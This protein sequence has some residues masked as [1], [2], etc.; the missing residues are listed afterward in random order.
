MRG[1]VEWWLPTQRIADSVSDVE[2]ALSNLIAS[3]QL[4]AHRA[5]DGQVFY[6][7]GSHTAAN[8]QNPE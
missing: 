4:T 7:L 5:A 8:R 6:H 1:I 2:T 3:G